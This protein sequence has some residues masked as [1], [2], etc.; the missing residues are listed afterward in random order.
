VREGPEGIGANEWKMAGTWDF[1]WSLPAPRSAAVASTFTMYT[2][3][4]LPGI[5]VTLA[6][7]AGE[8]DRGAGPGPRGLL[9]R[10]GRV[11]GGRVGGH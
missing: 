2:A 7:P 4:T 9:R 5:V 3:L 1:I 6:G 11:D 10:P 8:R